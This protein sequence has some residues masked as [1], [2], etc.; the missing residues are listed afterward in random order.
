MDVTY[1]GRSW[2]VLVALDANSGRVLYCCF[3]KSTERTIDYE[4]AI[5]ILEN[6]GY[7]IEA[8]VIDGRRGVR[9]ML[10]S[11]GIAVQ[12]CQ[13]HQ[14]LTITHCLTRRPRLIP[15][16]ELRRISLDLTKTT[17]SQ[18]EAALDDWHHQYGDWLKERDPITNK[19]IHRRTRQAYFGLRRNIPYLFVKN[20]R[21]IY[22]QLQTPP[23]PLTVVLV[24]GK[25]GSKST[26]DAA[27][28]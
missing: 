23:M 25:D 4:I 26:A 9:E 11:K 2:G 20:R 15:N 17:R 22:C 28:C 19:F 27:K 6:I 7:K 14:P 1:F 18:L 24:F 8:A 16:Q 5:N 3:L 21:T 13:F 10:K 12:H